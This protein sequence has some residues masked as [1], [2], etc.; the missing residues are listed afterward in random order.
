MRFVPRVII[1]IVGLVVLAGTASAQVSAGL[2]ELGGRG[3]FSAGKFGSEEKNLTS[4]E[5]NV[6][7]GRFLTDRWEIGPSLNFDKTQGEE[8]TGNA[9]AFVDYHFGD[10]TGKAVPFVEAAV[11]KFF[12][13][14]KGTILSVGPGLKWFFAGG[15]GSLVAFPYYRRV[16]YDESTVGYATRNEFAF[17]LGVAIYFP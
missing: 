1:A 4:V 8:F 10:T 15:G 16:M 2:N 13:G 9:T 11:G 17:S 14:D 6:Y 12:G 3:S 7:F 5:G